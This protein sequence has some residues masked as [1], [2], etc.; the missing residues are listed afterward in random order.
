MESREFL[1]WFDGI[2]K[3]SAEQRAQ[4][5]GRLSERGGEAK[6][7]LAVEGEAA[8]P[9]EPV[10]RST[11]GRDRLEALG[12]V[13]HVKVGVQGCPPL[14]GAE[15]RFVG[16][17]G[18]AGSLPLQGLSPHF[19]RAD[20]NA[21][22]AAT[23]EGAV[24]RLC[25]GHAGGN[26]RREGRAGLWGGLHNGVPVAPSLPDRARDRQAQAVPWTCRSGRDF[27]SRVLQGTSVRSAPAAAQAG[28]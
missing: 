23:Q 6:S 11:R 8:P 15:R 5:L 3:L 27:H 21:D 17:F 10:A 22:G 1:L 26:Q 24:A 14:F 28:R 18:W 2:G 9:R 20:Q 7:G 4:A 12:E 25:A 19:Q 16:P 13:G